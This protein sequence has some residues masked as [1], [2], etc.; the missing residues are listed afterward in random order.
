MKRYGRLKAILTD[1]LQYCGTSLNEL[2]RG[3][4]RKMGGWLNNREENSH[5]PFQRREREMLRFRRMRR[6]KASRRPCLDQQPLS[7][8]GPVPKPESCNKTK[9]NGL[10]HRLD[11]TH[12]CLLLL[13]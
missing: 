5:L 13:S 6:A 10:R 7:D 12:G 4:D 3:D 8:G 2:G 1:R 11:Q 9:V